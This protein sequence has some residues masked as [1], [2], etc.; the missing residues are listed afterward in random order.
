MGHC[1]FDITSEEM[2]L[3]SGLSIQSL[4]VIERAEVLFALVF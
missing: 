4:Y 3:T 1:E 2:C